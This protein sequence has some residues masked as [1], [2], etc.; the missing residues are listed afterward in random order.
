MTQDL[1]IFCAVSYM[2][3]GPS[4]A[5]SAARRLLSVPSAW[6]GK[7]QGH[8]GLFLLL[9]LPRVPWQAPDHLVTPAHTDCHA[10]TV[11]PMITMAGNVLCDISLASWEVTC[12]NSFLCCKSTNLSSFPVY[13]TQCGQAGA[14]L[15]MTLCFI[16]SDYLYSC[17]KCDYCQ[18]L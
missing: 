11:L 12:Q 4:D 16:L 13:P 17:S 10:G 15:L 18:K 5:Y 7:A 8:G 14:F 3:V 6:Q 2:S 1:S 9:P